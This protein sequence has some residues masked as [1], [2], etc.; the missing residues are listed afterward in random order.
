MVPWVPIG[1][2]EAATSRDWMKRGAMP[3]RRDS[4]SDLLIHGGGLKPARN[5]PGNAVTRRQ[6]DD[7]EPGVTRRLTAQ[8]TRQW[9]PRAVVPGL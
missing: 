3:I 4:A 5:R 9:L 7:D 6:H 8:R 2:N 1:S